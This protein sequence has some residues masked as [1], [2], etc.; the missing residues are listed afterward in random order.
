MA[1]LGTLTLDLI[2]KTG[3]FRS[4]L[5]QAETSLGNFVRRNKEAIR[6]ITRFTAA[7]AAASTA[8]LAAITKRT[9]EASAE[10]SRF[11]QLAGI[12]TTEFQKYAKA[13]EQVGFSQK[14]FADALKDVNDKLGDFFNTGAGPLADF[15]EQIAPK[16]GLTADAFRDLNSKEAL[17]LYV[18]SLEEANVSQG[19]FTFFLEA[20]ASDVTGLLPL[21]KDGGEAFKVLAENSAF[22]SPETIE[23]SEKLNAALFILNEDLT[24]VRQ[25]L[26]QD[27]LPVFVALSGGL[28]A[29][30]EDTVEATKDVNTLASS[31]ALLA[32]TGIGAKTG[33][34]LIAKTFAGGAA[35][36]TTAFFGTEDEAREAQLAFLEDIRNTALKGA[37]LLD[38]IDNA[39]S[40]GGILGGDAVEKRI[41]QVAD[42]LAKVRD[43]Q[44]GG[45]Q[46]NFA[47]VNDGLQKI[48]VS[49]TEV[50]TE[51]KQ[52]QI[53]VENYNNVVRDLRTDEEVLNDQLRERLDIL[54][55]INDAGNDE[56]RRRALDAAFTDAPVAAG[57]DAAVGGATSELMRL[58]EAADLLQEWYSDQ[59]DRLEEY[60]QQKLIT[61]AE[62]D[63]QE[64][65][66][67]RQREDQLLKIEQARQLASLVAAE[68]AFGSLA[69]ITK[70]FAGEQSTAYQALFALEKAAAIARSIIA[71][72][73]A[74]AQ[75]ATA[76]PFPA[77]LAA[78]ASVASATAGLISTIAST[79]IQGQAHDGLMSV[80]RT[81]TYILERGER[82][83][84]AETSAKMDAL[85]DDARKG[86][87]GGGV[88][89][90]NAWDTSMIG[91]YVGS[92]AGEKIVMNVIRKNTRTIKQL[93][94]A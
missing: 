45:S 50:S 64:K 89:V 63:E 2:A 14:D 27:V 13:A 34:E 25:N 90:I 6:T 24:R 76:G 60:R 59:L 22:I 53:D 83:S 65:E 86:S 85:I 15:F 26:L 40:E 23:Q 61:N 67:A 91:D 31:L 73:T 84:T 37:A 19:E 8:G 35:I 54:S 20:I 41:Q 88:R 5:K 87:A 12:S 9:V 29:V 1:T 75:A 32:K 36:L 58:N 72:Q 71:I 66:L 38:K 80:P 62:Y 28:V 82:V 77:N 92:S 39:A 56:Q 47:E 33:I 78:M 30:S 17:Q 68:D 3:G 43:L 44:Q 57:I 4:G 81:G 49:A 46:G 51:L 42:A 7:A 48:K 55:K 21:L 52:W 79:T 69:D 94:Q 11:A 70:T 93:A 18:T 10:V 16:V 74:I